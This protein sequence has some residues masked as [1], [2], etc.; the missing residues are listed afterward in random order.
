MNQAIHCFITGR[1]QGV[2]FRYYTQKQAQQLGLTGWV[3]NL[4]DG[5]VE[6]LACGDA[7]ALTSFQRWLQQGPSMAQ[8]TEVSCETVPV[9][10]FSQFE[11]TG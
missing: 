7:D 6:T 3:R 11:I 10:H 5:R 9:S 2:S 8:V 4:P 1:V